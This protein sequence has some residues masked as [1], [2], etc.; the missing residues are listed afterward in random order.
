[1]SRPRIAGVATG[2]PRDIWTGEYVDDDEN[3]TT[4]HLTEED[5]MHDINQTKR[6]VA[7]LTAF[8]AGL[9]A[10]SDK[11]QKTLSLEARSR[12]SGAGIELSAEEEA[13]IVSHGGSPKHALKAKALDQLHKLRASL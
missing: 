8:V 10:E 13:F 4:T 7:E 12:A 2:T 11:T 9:D 1:M 5:D 6:R 3:E